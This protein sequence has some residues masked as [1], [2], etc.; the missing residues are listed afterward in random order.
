VTA[1]S[2]VRSTI[3]SSRVHGWA[4]INVLRRTDHK[5]IWVENIRGFCFVGWEHL[6]VLYT[7]LLISF[8]TLTICG[9]EWEHCEK[10]KKEKNGAEYFG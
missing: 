4:G 5:S 2:M 8:I 3:K 9:P 6:L 10:K 1:V 7:S